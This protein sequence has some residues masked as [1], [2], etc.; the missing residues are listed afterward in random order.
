MPQ[1][2]ELKLVIF[3]NYN[4][5]ISPFSFFLFF[6]FLFSFLT[7]LPFFFF[8]FLF[9]FHFRSLQENGIIHEIPTQIGRLTLLTKLYLFYSLFFL[10]FSFCLCFP[11]PSLSLSYFSFLG[12][13]GILEVTNS[14]RKSQV[15]FTN[16]LNYYICMIFFNSWEEKEK[17]RREKQEK[18]EKQEKIEREFFFQPHRNI[19]SNSLEGT[20][21]HNIGQLSQL[22]QL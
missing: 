4:I 21:S 17:K 13:T 18:Q 12:N 8:F 3:L 10:S 16:L 9:L 14:K 20:I 5:C 7:I 15:K 6:S 11:S 22:K 2:Y 19:S 1:L